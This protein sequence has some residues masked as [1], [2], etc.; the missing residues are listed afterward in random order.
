MC[1]KYALVNISD[2]AAVYC[3]RDFTALRVLLICI[4]YEPLRNVNV[5][6]DLIFCSSESQWWIFHLSLITRARFIS[7]EIEAIMSVGIMGH[8]RERERETIFTRFSGC[9]F[10]FAKLL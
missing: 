3:C 8:L 1:N 10:S 4:Q 9:C 5:W 2:S 6:S 7:I